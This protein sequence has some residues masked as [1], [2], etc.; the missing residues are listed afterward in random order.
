[1]SQENVEV[2]KCGWDAWIKGDLNAVFELFDPA[3]EWDT[4]SFEGWPEDDLY[5]GHEAVRRFF[6]EWLATWE[7]F[8]TGAEAYL[9]VDDD[10]VLVLCW[11]RGFGS[12]SQVPVEMDWAQ[13]FTLKRG[14]ICRI[15]N[16]SDRRDALE[17]A[18]LRE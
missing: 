12:D 7:R 9:E 8:E 5:C 3:V 6:K 13:V 1:M 4:T 2:V 10:R 17:A 16:Y 14:L 15:E 11:Q 18:G